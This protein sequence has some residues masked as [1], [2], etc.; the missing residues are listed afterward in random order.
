MRILITGSSG[1]IGTNLALKLLDDG[2]EVF[3]VDKR[4]N[5][6]TK[7]FDDAPAGSRRPLRT[8][9]RRDDGV[10]WPEVDLVVHLAAHAKVHQ[11]VTPAAARAREHDDDLQRPRVLPRARAAARLLL[12]AR[13]LRRRPPLRGVRRGDGGLRL[14]GE[15]V[16]GVEDRA[17]RRS[18]TP[19]RSATA[20]AT[21]SSASRTSTGASTTTCSGWSGC[22]RCSC[23]S[24]R[25]ASR[26]RS[27][28]AT[29]RCSTSPSSTTASTAS[30]AA[31][32]ALAD[33]RVDERDDQPR[34]RAGQ[35]ARARGGAD[36]QPSSGSSR[37]STRAVARRRG[38][39]LR[40][41]H[42]QGARAA[43]LAAGDAARRR[44][45]A[46]RSTGSASGARSIPRRTAAIVRR[47]AGDIEHAFKRRPAP[48][49]NR[50]VALFGPTASGKTA[51][52]RATRRAARRRGR[53]PPTRPRSTPGIPI[54]TAAPPYPARLVGVV[55]LA[56]RVSVGEYQRLAHA[57][58]DE[59]LAA[60]RTPVV[61]GGTGL[62]LRAA[63]VGPRAA[64]AAAPG[65][66][67]RWGAR[68]DELGPRPRTRLLAERDPAAAGSRAPE[69]P[70][71]RRS[72]AR[73]RR[74]RR[75]ARAAR[76]ASGARTCAGRRSLVGLDARPRGARRADRGAGRARWSSTAP[77]RRRAPRGRRRS[78]R[79]RAKVLGLEEFATLPRRGGR[80]AR[81]S[82]RRAGSPATSASGCAGCRSSLPST[83]TGRRGD[84]R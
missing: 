2:H 35:H 48:A 45:P 28:A 5:P 24:W 16:L 18:S 39:A 53:S 11:L 74:G 64:A 1:Q 38:D 69:R 84:R 4:P 51:V 9:P 67:E 13:G 72:R 83:Q 6:W 76:T 21:S 31:S 43:R 78:R 46:A 17:P 79:R 49:R 62:Y 12:D 70:P 47:G 65:A 36:R 40:R 63:L 52:A 56:R 33:G 68:Y 25:A 75:L 73:A 34:L 19:T 44:H 27:T 10:E 61:A 54:L 80:R 60:G 20:F 7:R 32:S 58:I 59:M 71:A 81:S 8:L 3:G 37:R 55:P 42:P 41:R 29:R 30:R 66:R 23:T 82:R 57:A 26:S 50:V 14:H 15:P 77:S 22:C